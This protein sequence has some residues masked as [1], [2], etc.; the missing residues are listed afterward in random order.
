M[1][2][3]VDGAARVGEYGHPIYPL[4]VNPWALADFE[5]I[6]DPLWRPVLRRLDCG[7]VVAYAFDEGSQWSYVAEAVARQIG[8]SPETLHD[9][10]MTWLGQVELR[11]ESG[12]GRVRI[13]LPE[14]REDLTASLILRG[15][16]LAA[17]FGGLVD[18]PLVVGIGH[19]VE[20]M[21]CSRD[22]TGAVDGLRELSL[23]LYAGEG[24]GKP[25]SAE[26]LTLDTDGTI[27][28]LP[29]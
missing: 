6:P 9:E 1:V 12:G 14:G 15:R 21:I 22:D 8:H 20:L 24:A 2:N 10:A 26:L 18:G 23:A 5:V 3:P 27:G 7:L 29:G 19:R 11:A 25:V 4:L 17:A 13:Q 28:V 16:D